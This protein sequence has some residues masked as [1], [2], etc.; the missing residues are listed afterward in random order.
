MKTKAVSVL[1][2]AVFVITLT[3]P[4]FAGVDYSA[5]YEIDGTVDLKRQAGHLC[6]TG[7][8]QKQVIT[9]DGEISKTSNIVMVPGKI[10]VE[11]VNDFVAGETNLTVTSVIELCA[12][13]KYE[14]NELDILFDLP[15]DGPNPEEYEMVINELSSTW[16][17]FFAPGSS[18]YDTKLEL[19]NAALADINTL[20][21]DFENRRAS[22]ED[23]IE[24]PDQYY[25]DLSPEDREIIRQLFREVLEAYDQLL[26]YFRALH[27]AIK[28]NFFSASGAQ[29]VVDPRAIYSASDQPYI[30]GPDGFEG[31]NYDMADSYSY[32]NP[33]S[34]QIW[35]VQVSADPGFS[36]SL[37]QDFEAAYGPYSAG[38]QLRTGNDDWDGVADDAWGWASADFSDIVTGDNYAGNYFNIDQLTRTPM[39]TVQRFIDI[40]SPWSHGYLYED[41]S[42]VGASE[43]EE[44]FSMD[45]IAP[46]SDLISQ[47]WDLF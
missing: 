29:V 7:A 34:K 41:M 23:I 32:W 37:H 13:P 46:G 27:A 6:N 12:P 19:V 44:A 26:E 9:G 45:N 14:A 40:S 28:A 17:E 43:I 16:R 18:Q 15:Y 21:I 3:A 4:V 39:G 20:I 22:V 30:Y 31:M 38:G 42:V 8:E 1:L 47:W 36:G 11:D 25:D 2:A 24:N 10:T 5:V 33:V 35:A